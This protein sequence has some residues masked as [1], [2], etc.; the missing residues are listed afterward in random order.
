MEVVVHRGESVGEIILGLAI[1]IFVIWMIV[2]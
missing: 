1:A 2:A